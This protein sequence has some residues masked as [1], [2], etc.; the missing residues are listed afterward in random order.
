MNREELK[1]YCPQIIALSKRY[2]APN[3]RVFGLEPFCNP[4]EIGCD[5]QYLDSAESLGIGHPKAE[6]LYQKS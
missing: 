6:C 3:I 5:Q 1:A 4:K 2:H